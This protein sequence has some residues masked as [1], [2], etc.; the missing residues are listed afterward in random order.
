MLKD[1]RDLYTVSLIA[2]AG[3]SKSCSLE[4]IKDAENGDFVSAR[5]NMKRANESLLE[6]HRIH[7]QLLTID[8]SEEGPVPVDMLMIHVST[9]LSNAELLADL[10]QHFVTILEKKGA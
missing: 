6:A 5:E 7:S 3:E 10:S 9:H 4:A 2:N 8:A 1:D